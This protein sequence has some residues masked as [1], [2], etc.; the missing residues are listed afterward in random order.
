MSNEGLNN[1]IFHASGGSEATRCLG[2]GHAQIAPHT[3]PF[4]TEVHDDF[5]THCTCCTD[6]QRECR[7]DT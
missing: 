4:R 7:E 3:C 6:C 2:G 1:L 5:V